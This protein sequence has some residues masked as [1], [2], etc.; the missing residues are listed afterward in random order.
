M[1]PPPTT[2]TRSLHLLPT[3]TL[4]S[5]TITL[6]LK[7]QKMLLIQHIPTKEI[8]FPKGRKNINESLP[9]AAL[10]E[11]YEETGFRVSLLS[12]PNI[13]TPTVPVP[14][15]D[16]AGKCNQSGNSTQGG[17]ASTEPIAVT[18]RVLSDNTVKIIFWFAAEGDSMAKA[19]T[20]TQEEGEEFEAGWVG[21]D[22]VQGVLTFEDDRRL[23]GWVVA[24]ARQLG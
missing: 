5:G 18:Q 22:D 4:S 13:S 6:D 21:W 10:R 20:G 11:T 24:A 14:I 12:L 1:P 3:F 19:E 7:T 16:L 2:I 15:P 17:C 8:Y 23:A 9:D